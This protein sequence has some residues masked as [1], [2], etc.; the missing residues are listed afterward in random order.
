MN[1]LLSNYYVGIW[2]AAL[3][4]WKQRVLNTTLKPY[5]KYFLFA[6]SGD[7][8]CFDQSD[9]IIKPLK[10][11]WSAFPNFGPHNTLFIDDTLNT[12]CLNPDN[13]L[14]IKPFI[15]TN[16][17][18]DNELFKIFSVLESTKPIPSLIKEKYNKLK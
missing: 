11:V 7:Q 9:N 16:S 18:K 8:V 13:H 14:H 4:M 17:K 2:T 5:S 12:G 3:P 15:V 6:W 10:L 1:Y